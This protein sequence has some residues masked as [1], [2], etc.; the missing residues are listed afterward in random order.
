MVKLKEQLIVSFE[1]I[2]GSGKSTM[3]NT[4]KEF[5]MAQGLTVEV[6]SPFSAT[7]LGKA[8]REL[9]LDSSNY[10]SSNTEVLAMMGS[11]SAL[12][13]YMKQS[14]ADFILIDRYILSFNAY[15]V[16]GR[17]NKLAKILYTNTKILKTTF[18]ILL[19]VDLSTSKERMKARN[20]A[21]DNFDSSGDNFKIAIINGYRDAI[22]YNISN[23]I[24]VDANK[25]LQEVTDKVIEI[26]KTHID[27]YKI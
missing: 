11:V 8:T 20:I 6:V 10:V 26:F 12:S 22:K 9:V 14:T 1:G 23:I 19:D 13:D 17:N 16:V 2:D 5:L 4:V 3:I 24:K 27:L 18:D 25:E 21:L 15:Q 7:V